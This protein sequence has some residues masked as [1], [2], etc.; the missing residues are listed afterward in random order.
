MKIRNVALATSSNKISC[1]FF[2][3]LFYLYIYMNY[4]LL[5]ILSYKYYIVNIRN[6]YKCILFIILCILFIFFLFFSGDLHIFTC[7]YII[8]FLFSIKLYY[9]FVCRFGQHLLLQS[10][11][12]ADRWRKPKRWRSRWCRAPP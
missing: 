4:Y 11:T 5:Y 6:K 10:S 2:Y 7:E 9:F 3:V 1:W 8:G 12:R